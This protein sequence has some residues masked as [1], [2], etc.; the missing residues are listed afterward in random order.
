MDLSL[1]VLGKLKCN[2]SAS[3]EKD[4]N[5]ECKWVLRTYLHLKF[6]IV[7]FRVELLRLLLY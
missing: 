1:E 3:Q 7:I 4:P 6:R 5:F 2:S